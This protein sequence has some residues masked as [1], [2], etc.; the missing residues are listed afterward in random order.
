MR[1]CPSCGQPKPLT[2]YRIR[3]DRGGRREGAC[4][5]CRKQQCRNSRVHGKNRDFYSELHAEPRT[6]QA[7]ANDLQRRRDRGERYCERGARC[8]A[9]AELG[10][11]A[12]LRRTSEEEFCERCGEEKRGVA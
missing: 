6:D 1:P 10:E 9:V 8:R 2:D 11:S 5:A 7:V 4:L 12:K 3:Y